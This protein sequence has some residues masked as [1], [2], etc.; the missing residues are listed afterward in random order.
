MQSPGQL[1]P[2][3]GTAMMAKLKVM[4]VQTDK[5]RDEK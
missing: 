1:G 3:G 2:D 4:M 5:E